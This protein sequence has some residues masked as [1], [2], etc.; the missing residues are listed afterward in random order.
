VRWGLALFRYGVV[1]IGLLLAYGLYYY[2]HD[3]AEDFVARKGTLVQCDI[4]Q[5]GADSLGLHTRVTLRSSSGLKVVGG[6]ITPAGIIVHRRYPAIVILGGKTNGNH[7]LE[8]AFGISNL[9]SMALDYRY[10]ARESYSTRTLVADIWENRD[11]ALDLFPSA[12]L[13]V[14]YL[15]SRPDVDTTKIILLGYNFGAPFV[16]GIV[17]TDH[18]FSFAAMVYGCG[19]FRTLFKYNVARY[20]G[21]IVGDVAG[22]FAEV[23]LWPGEP[24]RYA[25]RITPT[26]LLMINGEKDE[27]VPRANTEEFYAAAPEPKRIIWLNSGHVRPENFALTENIVAK[28]GEE[29]H[30]KGLLPAGTQP[31]FV[32]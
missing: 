24:M 13:A 20:E 1:T 3:S 31:Y 22:A 32:R 4:E 21:P 9:V 16:P 7:G 23:L 12:Q 27:F 17:A 19:D 15:C 2:Q 28:L 14:D 8:Y 30:A 25:D 18:R 5:Q 11:A 26:P 6:L 10:E 29:L